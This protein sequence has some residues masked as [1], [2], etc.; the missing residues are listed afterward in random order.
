MAM[1]ELPG[2]MLYNLPGIDGLAYHNN[3][4]HAMLLSALAVILK[5]IMWSFTL[6]HS[7]FFYTSQ[8][9]LDAIMYGHAR[10]AVLYIVYMHIDNFQEWGA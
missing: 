1:H 7:L 3:T 10:L 6:A 4:F 2:A 8:T 9:L 5:M